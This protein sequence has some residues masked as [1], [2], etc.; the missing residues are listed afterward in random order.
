MTRL[1]AWVVMVPLLALSTYVV[2]IVG[3]AGA[4]NAAMDRCS[5][6]SG[7]GSVWLEWSWR[8]FAWRCHVE[9]GTRELSV[10]EVLGAGGAAGTCG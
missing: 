7:A 10:A 6:I 9:N 8:S 2:A 3:A 4:H 5:K 1:V